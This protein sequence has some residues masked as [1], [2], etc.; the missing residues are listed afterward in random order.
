MENPRVRRNIREF[1]ADTPIKLLKD[2]FEALQLHDLVELLEEAKPGTL[3]PALPL[4][5]IGKLTNAS[6][7]PITYYSKARVLIIDYRSSGHGD[8]ERFGSFFKALNSWS[9]I[10][11]I[12]AM[13][14]FEVS[15]ILK[16]MKQL[17]ITMEH[18]VRYHELCLTERE[19]QMKME[20]V[21]EERKQWAKEGKQKMEKEIKEKKEELQREK[22]KILVDFLTTLNK[23]AHEEG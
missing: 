22:D 8:A 7:R 15:K 20:E 14:L 4:I 18:R 5:E 3:R 2:V 21:V 13:P 9:E 23:W 12:T 17:K 16:E 10:A 1:F 19:S 6:N 11:T